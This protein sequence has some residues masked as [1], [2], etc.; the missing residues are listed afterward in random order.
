MALLVEKP[1]RRFCQHAQAS[2]NTNL[3]PRPAGLDYSPDLSTGDARGPAARKNAKVRPASGAGS[4]PLCP[5]REVSEP[6]LWSVRAL[7]ARTRIRSLRSS[8]GCKGN[9]RQQPGGGREHARRP[10]ARDSK[11]PHTGQGREVCQKKEAD[12]SMSSGIR[13]H[14]GRQRCSSTGGPDL[15]QREH[16]ASRPL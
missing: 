6:R 5:A 16:G 3:P 2:V 1:W 7:G 14:C 13:P 8:R 11:H 10:R 15:I 9:R 12:C 4:R